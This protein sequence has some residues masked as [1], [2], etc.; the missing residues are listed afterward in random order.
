MKASASRLRVKSTISTTDASLSS[1]AT[2][3]SATKKSSVLSLGFLRG[4]ASRKSLQSD[5]ER[6][7]EKSERAQ[8][9]LTKDAEKL[10]EKERKKDEKDR[11]ES[12]ISVLM[13]RKRGKVSFIT[14]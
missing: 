8:R 11:S 7:D 2:P 5:T 14:P 12:R 6:Q 13:G 3:A 10:V 1:P 4:S 9:R